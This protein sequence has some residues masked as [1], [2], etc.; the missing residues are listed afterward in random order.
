M[1]GIAWRER[2]DVD[3]EF[4][5]YMMAITCSFYASDMHLITIDYAIKYKCT[6]I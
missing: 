4:S 3:S 5:N 6:V 2:P 1:L